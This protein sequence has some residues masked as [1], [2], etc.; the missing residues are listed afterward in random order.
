MGDDDV[1]NCSVA[2]RT[3][4]PAVANEGENALTPVEL[5]QSMTLRST[6]IS[7][8]ILGMVLVCS[9]CSISGVTEWTIWTSSFQRINEGL[10]KY[11]APMVIIIY[12]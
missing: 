4:V 11:R 5:M 1:V 8:I 7:F 10:V 12:Y 9:L 3:G 6:R 2:D